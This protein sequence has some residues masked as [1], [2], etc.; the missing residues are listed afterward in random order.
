M[1]D[2]EP[3]D[4]V[5]VGAGP[6]GAVV[7]EHLAR[8]GL[9][10]VCL[11]QGDWVSSTSYPSD[12]PEWELLAMSSWHHDPN[13]NKRPEDY[14]LDNSESDMFPVMM[15][16]VGGASIVYGACWHRFLPSDYRVRT[17]D[18]VADDWPVSYDEM[19]PYYDAVDKVLGVS[20]L[21]GDPAYPP[22]IEHPLPPH[23]LNKYGRVA[24]EAMNRLGWHWWP[25]PLAIASQP[26]G[27]LARCSRWGVCEWGCPEGAKAS[28]DMTYWPMALQN[29][30][31]LITGARVRE[32]ATDEQGRASGAIYIDRDGREHF[33]AGSAVVMAANGIGT[34]RL[35][36]LS[37]SRYHLDGLANSSGLVGR[38]LMLH[39][40]ASVNGYYDLDLES[41]L[42]PFSQVLHSLQFYGTDP[43]RDFVRG[44]KWQVV[45]SVGV[46][47]NLFSN[48]DLPFE[49]RWGAA[50]HQLISETVGR[51]L[52]WCLGTEDL[53]D[54]A[55]RVTLDPELKDSDGIPAP[56]IRYRISENT[57]RM[58]RFNLDRMQEAH[59]AGGAI[60]TVE[61]ELWL[62]EPGHLLGTARMGNDPATSVVD[63][64]GRAHDVDNL[65]IVDG[66]IFVTAGAMNPTSMICALALRT[67]EHIVATAPSAKGAS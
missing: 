63:K 32:I 49:E 50:V 12:K 43:A 4:V 59:E 9:S 13:V 18:G 58:I 48:S 67:A 27:Q 30:A 45:P 40:N 36:L 60:R 47:M 21:S 53:P 64:Y 17:L 3:T 65:F 42:G 52:Q 11:E 44:A 25:S 5:I 15:A 28:F 20:G 33:Q 7:A 38:R 24:A 55:N 10:V 46:L 6:S 35:L 54:E 62:D 61:Q 8:H 14:P 51:G 31:K 41:W 39:P 57:R 1:S 56:R 26:Y 2:Q 66:S 34:P 23:P 19:T 29:G 22:G 37:K 16:A